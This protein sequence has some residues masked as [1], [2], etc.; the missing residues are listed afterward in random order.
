MMP[1]PP[2]S[3]CR[4]RMR[5]SRG[6][7]CRSRPG[8]SPGRPRS[9]SS[10]PSSRCRS[11][12]ASRASRRRAGGR[13]APRLSRVL[14]SIPVQVALR[15][16]RRLPALADGLRGA[17]R[18]RGAG[19]QLRADLRLRHRLARLSRCSACF[20]GDVF[21]SFN[22]WRAIGRV[23]GRVQRDQ[24]GSGPPTPATRSGS[25]AGRRRSAWSPSSGSRSS[26]GQSG[27]VSV[28]L[29]PHT[30]AVAALVYTAYTLAMMALFGT[31]KWCRRGEVFSVYFG[32]F[33][34]LAPLEAREGSLGRRRPFSG[35]ARWATV[36]G[37][38]AV[39]IASIGDDEL[40]RRPGG[41]A[42]GRDREHLRL[43]GRR[44]GSG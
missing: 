22:P 20:F 1:A 35:A 30:T 6:R 16:A 19:P 8:C 42:Q 41:G 5:W 9:S 4:S 39:V 27:G 31:E 24:S 28:G 7:T 37:S 34:Q 23:T 17:A 29:S 32:M 26:T 36:P 25:A 12:G 14:L 38:L 43:A 15:R 21:R 33:S 44:R 11:A 18:D 40:R 3:R 10:S 2:A 13:S